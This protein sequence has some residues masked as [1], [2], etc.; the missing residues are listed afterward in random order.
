[1][2]QNKKLKL[3]LIILLI[4]LVS[5]LSF[6]GIYVQNKGLIENK[7]PEYLLARDLKGYRKVELKVSDDIKKVSYDAEGKKIDAHDTTT[8]A[9]RTEEVKVNS[10][11]SLT[12]ENY[13]ISKKVIE[14]RLDNMGVK[15]YEI[16]QNL[17]DGKIV[18]ELP[19]NDDTDRVVGNIYLQGKIEVVDN[20]TEE[21]LMTNDNVESVK[22]GYGTSQARTSAI[23]INIQFNKEET[24]KFKNITNTYVATNQIVIGDDGQQKEET[25]KKQ[26]SLTIDDEALIT[27][28]FDQEVSNGLMQLT[29]SVPEGTKTEE[30]QEYLVE[31][32]NISSI[33]DA[34]KTGVVY[35]IEQN[36]FIYSDITTKQLSIFVAI[37]IAVAAIG[38]VYLVIKFKE[39]GILVGIS[40]IGYAAVLLITLRYTNVEI[41]VGGIAILTFSLVLDYLMTFYMLKKENV[42]DT[43]KKFT[44]M[45]IPALIISVVFTLMNVTIGAVLFWSIVVILLYNLVITKSLLK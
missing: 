26:I 1:M 21:V 11:E 4:V 3:T 2:K 24:E 12:K 7:M 40:I 25:V 18:L 15:D 19:E 10:D 36:K 41:S 20:D 17:E 33:M 35:E 22:S 5:M 30:I 27:T 44:L 14:K 8:E 45:Y 38:I 16:R 13:E 34:G 28:Y 9:V 37:V 29:I 39:K 23:F 31:A 32:N 42:M 6:G 43:I